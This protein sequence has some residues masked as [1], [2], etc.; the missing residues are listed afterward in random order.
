MIANDVVDVANSFCCWDWPH[1]LVQPLSGRTFSAKR[2]RTTTSPLL[3]CPRTDN[4]FR[5]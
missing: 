5:T 3:L 1:T 4:S 2:D